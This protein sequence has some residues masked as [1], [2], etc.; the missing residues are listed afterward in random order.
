MHR[1]IKNLRH[2]IVRAGQQVV[3]AIILAFHVIAFAL[4]TIPESITSA[5][6]LSDLAWDQL[7]SPSPNSPAGNLSFRLIMCWMNHIDEVIIPRLHA[8]IIPRSR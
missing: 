2:L 8:R 3:V 1:Y 5:T 6:S 7:S 4:L